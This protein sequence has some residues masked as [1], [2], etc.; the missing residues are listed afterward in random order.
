MDKFE[1]SSN[2][3]KFTTMPPAKLLIRDIDV[4]ARYGAM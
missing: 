2:I 3:I 1:P 4:F